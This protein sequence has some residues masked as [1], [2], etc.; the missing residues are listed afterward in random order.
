METAS[1][2]DG[3]G[4]G[5]P[6][7]PGPEVDLSPARSGNR[8]P[9]DELRASLAAVRA[10]REAAQV[11]LRRDSR[12]VRVASVVCLAAFAAGA[13]A[14]MGHLRRAR[15]APGAGALVAVA[16]AAPPAS[17][18]IAT[19]GMGAALTPSAAGAALPTAAPPSPT[20]ASAGLAPSAA[21]GDPAAG[22]APPTAGTAALAVAARDAEKAVAACGDA[23]EGHHWR[24]AVDA[25]AIAFEARPREVALAMKVAQAQ[26]ARGRYADAGEWARRALALDG[27]DPE[28]LVILA[29]AER[30]AGHPAAAKSAYRRYLVLAP[31]GWHASEARTAV[32]G[33]ERVRPRVRAESSLAAP[34]AAPF[35]SSEPTAADPR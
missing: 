25:C 8:P 26:H 23:Y 22:D 7:T 16:A 24:A 34:A 14:M 19:A 12:R 2:E 32:H 3:A 13:V 1:Q 4:E 5:S 17:S 15:R 31:R 33:G 21:A 18:G 9:S 35:A 20:S 28:A 10:A 30:R 27:V 6:S 11:R 29:H